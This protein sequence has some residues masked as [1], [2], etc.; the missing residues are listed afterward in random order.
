MTEPRPAP[1]VKCPCGNTI[2]CIAFT[3]HCTQCGADYSFDG[4]RLAP[5]EQWGEETGE[6][7][8]DILRETSYH[9]E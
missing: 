8:A 4:G 1:V 2:H 5:R 3:N 9:E 7:A 6:T